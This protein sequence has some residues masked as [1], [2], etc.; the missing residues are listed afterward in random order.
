MNDF[1][2]GQLRTLIQIVEQSE[3]TMML[4]AVQDD[5]VITKVEQKELSK[6]RAINNDYIKSLRKLLDK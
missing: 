4:S 2:K 5:G 3:K 1:T 6:L